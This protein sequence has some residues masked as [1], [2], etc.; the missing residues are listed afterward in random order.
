MTSSYPSLIEVYESLLQ[1]PGFLVVLPSVNLLIGTLT[2]TLNTF[3]AQF[4]RSKTN[5][6]MH[7]IYFVLACSDWVAGLA[8]IIQ[9]GALILFSYH[10]GVLAMMCP[11]FYVLGQVALHTSAMYTVLLTIVRSLII[12]EPAYSVNRRATVASIIGIPVFWT[13]TAVLEIFLAR[14]LLY[15]PHIQ[16]GRNLTIATVKDMIVFPR[17]GTA[18]VY[19][20]TCKTGLMSPADCSS[21][22]NWIMDLVATFVTLILP[23]GAPI[24]ICLLSTTYQLCNLVLKRSSKLKVSRARRRLTKTIIIL[25]ATFLIFDCVQFTAVVITILGQFHF[26]LTQALLF[27]FASYPLLCLNSMI[28]P[29]VMCLRGCSLNEHVKGKLNFVT[30]RTHGNVVCQDPNTLRSAQTYV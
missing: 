23:Y 15:P 11:V 9:G 26:N 5:S 28:T 22:Q 10:P 24:L 2:L 7:L 17:P 6:T 30:R 14:Y 4:F 8:L 19:S 16:T 13:V 21:D 25:T 20:I 27:S 3:T 29:L 12:R 18:V 1:S